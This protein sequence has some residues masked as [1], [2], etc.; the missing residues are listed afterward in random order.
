MLLKQFV[1]KKYPISHTTNDIP[2]T[3]VK[4]LSKET[5]QHSTTRVISCPSSFDLTRQRYSVI[6]FRQLRSAHVNDTRLMSL[7]SAKFSEGVW[8]WV[9]LIFFIGTYATY[10]VNADCFLKAYCIYRDTHFCL[11]YLSFFNEISLL[12]VYSLNKSDKVCNAV[13]PV[14]C[15][16]GWNHVH[17]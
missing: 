2:Q 13:S 12:Y 10:Q 1:Y 11:F 15:V 4:G 6:V 14:V 9:F 7:S 3:P 17:S 16:Q 8:V 5:G